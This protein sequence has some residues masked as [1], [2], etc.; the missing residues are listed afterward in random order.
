[1][2]NKYAFIKEIDDDNCR[3]IIN[4]LDSYKKNTNQIEIN[5]KNT[6]INKN[7]YGLIIDLDTIWSE[8]YF[9]TNIRFK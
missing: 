9:Y 3:F 4:V 6:S 5:M 8:P 2:N 1:M 7:N